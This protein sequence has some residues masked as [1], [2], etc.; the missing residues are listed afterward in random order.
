MRIR[1]TLHY[2]NIYRD[3]YDD[4]VQSDF[5]SDLVFTYIRAMLSDDDMNRLEA[6]TYNGDTVHPDTT[7][8]FPPEPGY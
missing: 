8:L 2:V 5:D 1:F 6:V 4:I 7:R 3:D